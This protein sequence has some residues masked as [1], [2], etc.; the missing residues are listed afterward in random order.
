[1]SRRETSSALFRRAVEVTPGGVNSPVRA[2]RSVG[3]EPFFVDRAQG[4]RIRD[5][6]GNEYIDYVLSW[7]PM[8]LGHAH[9]AVVAAVCDAARNGTSYGAPTE[10][11]VELAELVRELVPS[12]ER[13]RFVSSGTEATMSAVRLAR[14]FTGREFILK[15][16]GCYHG[17]GDSFLVKAGSG[18]ATLGLPNSPGVPAELSK[19]T[20]T[21]PFNDVEAV[22]AV[23]RAYAGSI[24][25]VILEPVVGNAGFIPPDDGFLPML[26]R[27]T[28]EDGAL[29]VF[30]EVM[31]GFRVARGGA[32]ERFGVR[33]DLTTLGK[34]IGGGLPVGAY[35]GRREIMDRIAPVG[36]VYQAGTLSGNP[37]AMAAGLAQLRILRDEDPYP[38][39]ERR[40]AR[41]VA[42]M[43]EAA[44]EM[45]VP[46][47]GGSLGSMWGF[48]FT[49]G[50]VRSFDDAKRSD[51]P[52]FNRFFHAMLDRG[53]F[54]APSQFEAGF[55]STAHGDAEIE[56]TIGRA[57][58]ALRAALG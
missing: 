9:P 29:L 58:E 5:V 27:I 47:S 19:L 43:L 33:P 15:F 32:Q 55:T 28:E 52:L 2:F 25:A 40:T 22:E 7:G 11:E 21:A 30:D 10:R 16:D 36:P 13:V 6:D 57:G 39:L 31:T 48:F 24:A 8:I 23:F 26:R 45:G 38:A 51:V 37:L 35:G 1:M 41:L 12:M 42:G 34:V 46:A 4:A 53:V 20:L 49:A 18:V 17:H 44:G 56:E 50:P 14:G 3:G 54:L